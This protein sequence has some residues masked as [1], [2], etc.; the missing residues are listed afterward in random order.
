MGLQQRAKSLIGSYSRGM[1]QR[2]GIA[3]ALV[4]SPAVVFLDEPTLGLDP[5]GQQ[6]LLALVRRIARDRNTGVVL[7]SHLLAEVESVCD[8]VVI[9]NSGRI[10]AQ[11]TVA[12]VIGGTQRNVLRIRVPTSSVA[13]A[14]QVLG[15]MPNIAQVTLTG[16]TADWLRVELA[17]RTGETSAEDPHLKTAVLAALI[18]AEIPIASFEAN[19]RA[20][21]RGVL[22]AHR[23]GDPMSDKRN[24]NDRRTRSAGNMPAWWIVFTNELADLWIGGKGLILVTLY[25]IILG[26][27]AYA[28]ATNSELSMIPAKELVYETLKTAIAVGS[29]IGLII[30]ADSISGERER[31]TLE[32]L[33]LTPTSRRQLVLGKFLAALSVWPA[34]LVITVPF[35]ACWLKGAQCLVTR[36]CGACCWG[37]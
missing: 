36:W 22:A 17:N 26:V 14:Q 1:R 20:A 9:L 33:L 2:L 5:R 18:R 31:A 15:A 6:E 29:F 11:G 30:G 37:V 34:T 16:A 13:Q 24:M 35:S 3:R 8:D 19:T 7:C 27:Q 25:A 21:A 10:V 12:E 23:G 32:G 4:H 28:D